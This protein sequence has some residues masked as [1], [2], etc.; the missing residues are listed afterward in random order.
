MIWLIS[1]AER[2][3]GRRV[4]A[5]PNSASSHPYL[6]GVPVMKHGSRCLPPSLY[7]RRWWQ[8]ALRL[9]WAGDDVGSGRRFCVTTVACLGQG[10]LLS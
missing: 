5:I 3:E 6:T 7:K 2:R 8:Q 10:R 4:D 1:D 9:H